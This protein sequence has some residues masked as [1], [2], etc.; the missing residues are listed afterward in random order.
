LPS[1]NLILNSG[2]IGVGTTPTYPI[3][4]TSS[5]LNNS[6][7][8]GYLG[9]GGAGT[10]GSTGAYIG[11]YTTQDSAASRFL[12][13]SDSRIKYNIL[14]MDDASALDTLR[15]IQP[16]RYNY[17]DIKKNG[18]EPVWGFIAQQVEEV[19]PYAVKTTSDFIPNIYKIANVSGKIL[20]FDENVV[21]DENEI[22]SSLRIFTET[23]K[24]LYV[25]VE[26]VLD[27]YTLI[28]KD[29]L[30]ESRIFVYGQKVDNFKNLDKNSIFT[31]SV[32]A[33]Q[34]I[35]KELQET[36]IKVQ[37]LE[38]ENLILKQKIDQILAYLSITITI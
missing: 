8:G 17:I 18:S 37:S 38:Q 36:K 15:Q 26:Q 13:F 6:I 3:H 28:L 9:S 1:H 22:S 29:T 16:K 12:A 10:T 35:D 33:V 11:I 14:D 23:N 19:L 2:K 20:T 32:A 21:F 4:V 31:I 27:T 24:E 7:E 5:E 34:Q 25:E 30:N